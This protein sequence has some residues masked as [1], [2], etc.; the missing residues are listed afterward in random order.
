MA[1]TK[2]S[3]SMISG[4]VV[5]VLDFGADNTGTTDSSTAIQSAIDSLVQ[6]SFELK[7]GQTATNV[8]LGKVY[9][10][11]GTYKIAAGI[12][13]TQGYGFIFEGESRGGVRLLWT[14]SGGTAI[15]LTDCAYTQVNNLEVY[16]DPTSTLDAGIACIQ[17]STLNQIAPTANIIENVMV[18]GNEVL[19]NAY[20][21]DYTSAS[22]NNDFHQFNSCGA[23]GYNNAAAYLRGLQS[24]CI[25]FRNV[26]INGGNLT[27]T[28]NNGDYGIYADVNSGGCPSFI[29][30]G[31]ALGW[32]A[33]ADY[34]LAGSSAN[35]TTIKNISSENSDRLLITANLNGSNN[36]LLDG[37]RYASDNLNADGYMIKNEL[38]GSLHIMNC[39]LGTG[40][41]AVASQPV[42]Y[43]GNNNSITS[44]IENT[45]FAFSYLAGPDDSTKFSPVF[46]NSTQETYADITLKNCQFTNALVTTMA[47]YLK[48][49]DPSTTVLTAYYGDNTHWI[50]QS[51]S[52]NITHIRPSYPNQKIRLVLMNLNT[53]LI[54]NSAVAGTGKLFL[55][56]ATDFTPTINPAILEFQWNV[57]FGR[58]VQIS[59]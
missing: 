2:A 52:A 34:Y 27:S 44:I 54:H 9:L 19:T 4:A 50:E 53:T 22:A 26:N 6:A 56:G 59:N 16:A 11:N 51:A 35:G 58:W 25:Y 7:D 15:K 47:A 13:I 38:S 55:N 12:V 41:S 32:H 43:F 30:D 42:I 37:V 31:G 49:T 24:H 14:G 5:N 39:A 28:A 46:V 29:V 21:V 33:V 20:V 36:I 45:R 40:G 10:P 48:T 18:V 8:T 23:R 57:P 3:Y 1:L 17:D